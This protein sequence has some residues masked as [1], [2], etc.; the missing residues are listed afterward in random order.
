VVRFVHTSDWQLGMRRHFLSDEA[1]PRFTVDRINAISTIARVASEH[2]CQFAVVAGDVFED[3]AIDRQTIARALDA[4]AATHLPFYLLPGNHDPLNEASI[5]QSKTF[6][7]HKPANVTVLQAGAPLVVAPGVE[8]VAA[9]WTSKHPVHDLVGEAIR[10][11]APTDNALR[12][13]VGHG[14]TARM[15][16]DNPAV[17]DL[18][19]VER[20]F[21]DRVIHYLAL[22]DRHSRTQ[23]GSSERA[24]YSGAPE[25]TDYDELDPRKVLV[26]DLQSDRCGVEPVPVARWRFI[27]KRFDLNGRSDLDTLGDWLDELPDKSTTILKLS[28]QGTL[29]LMD[30]LRLDVILDRARAL[31]GAVELWER[32]TELAVITD[33]TDFGDLGLTGFADATLRELQAVATTPGPAGETANDA[34]ALLFRLAGGVA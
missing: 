25:P 8:I 22:G 3:N 19:L 2:R 18:P 9:P 24:W 14:T 27:E 15:G 26:V 10:E 13:L 29:H 31:V 6:L 11:L 20:A 33:E 16:A 5:Y 23:A 34:L 17:I 12:I 1:Q 32:Q 21:A 4:M 28:F 30:R 7:E